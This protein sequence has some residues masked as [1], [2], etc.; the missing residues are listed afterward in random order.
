MA[1]GRPQATGPRPP[2]PK[3]H[4]FRSCRSPRLPCRRSTEGVA[5][6]IAAKSE[7]FYKAEVWA[8]AF[9]AD[10]EQFVRA[11]TLPRGGAARAPPSPEMGEGFSGRAVPVDALADL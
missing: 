2:S 10:D 7:G 1:S 5:R 11:L 9:P 3:P 4:H 8:R 6:I